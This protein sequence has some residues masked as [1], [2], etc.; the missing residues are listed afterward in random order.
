MCIPTQFSIL[1]FILTVH[2]IR[3]YALRKRSKELEEVNTALKIQIDERMRLEEFKPRVL[4]TF[5]RNKL[6]D[7]VYLRLVGENLAKQVGA[8]GVVI[9]ILNEDGSVD[10][11]RTRGLVD[12]AT[13]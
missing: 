12:L 7:R 11:E 4:T 9:G 5:V 6:I 10:K 1:F 2:K 3:T 13:R 8:N